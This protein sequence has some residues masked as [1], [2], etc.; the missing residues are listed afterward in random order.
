MEH[1]AV[2]VASVGPAE[3]DCE[4]MLIVIVR[5]TIGV[6]P[7]SFS[8]AE[9]VVTWLLAMTVGLLAVKL[10]VVCS[11]VIVNEADAELAA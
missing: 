11:F 1:D 8:V 6:V 10:T 2:P 3:Q 4:P 9:K 7:S 5:P